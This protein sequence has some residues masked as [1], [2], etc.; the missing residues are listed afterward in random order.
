MEGDTSLKKEIKIQEKKD[1]QWETKWHVM[2]RNS[3]SVGW[4]K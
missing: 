4:H 3:E 1:I 2:E